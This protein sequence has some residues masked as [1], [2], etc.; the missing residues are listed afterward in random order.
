MELLICPLQPITAGWTMGNVSSVYLQYQSAGDQ[1]VGRT[2]CGLNPADSTFS[3]LP[4]RFKPD[5]NPDMLLST[6]FCDYHSATPELKNVLKM[7]TASVIYHHEWIMN[8]LPEGHPFL[9]TTLFRCVFDRP[10][11][12]MVE[13][14]TWKPGD[15]IKATGIPPHVSLL[16][17]MSEMMDCMKIIP[18]RIRALLDERLEDHHGF[19]TQASSQQLKDLMIDAFQNALERSHI[20]GDAEVHDVAPHPDLF[21]RPELCMSEKNK[22]TFLPPDFKLPGKT[23]KDAWIAY[24]CWDDRKIVPPLCTVRGTFMPDKLRK[25]FCKYKKL[26]EAIVNEA[27]R[28]N[29]WVEPTDPASALSILAKVDLTNII[30]ETTKKNRKRRLD[31]LSWT[32]L[33]KDLYRS[34]HPAEAAAAAGEESD[35]DE[36]GDADPHDDDS[37]E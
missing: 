1:H 17:S 11:S 15:I 7:T 19:L 20:H 37:D 21:R 26:M 12:D 8:T 35:Q 13:C 18:D 33:V 36:E 5:Y 25:P 24:C 30:P 16:L 2:V 27:K 6:L 32:T 10:L 31:Q 29:V 23:L 14:H 4:P 22:L 9:S 34:R 28:L 3:V